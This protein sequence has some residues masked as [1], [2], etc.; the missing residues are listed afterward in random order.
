MPELVTCTLAETGKLKR[1]ESFI[2]FVWRFLTDH[3]PICLKQVF[4]SS[5]LFSPAFLYCYNESQAQPLLPQLSADQ[6]SWL[7]LLRDATM[8]TWIFKKWTGFHCQQRQETKMTPVFVSRR[9]GTG[10]PTLGIFGIFGLATDNGVPVHA[11]ITHPT[12]QDMI[13]LHNFPT[14]NTHLIKLTRILV[15]YSKMN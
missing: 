3:Q 9:S 2:L 8:T 5:Y 10:F 6:L 15:S 14:W 7:Q 13:S 11:H 1:P 12:Q 4:Y